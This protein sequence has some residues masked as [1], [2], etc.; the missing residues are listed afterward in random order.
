[1]TSW[2]KRRS[3]RPIFAVGAGTLAW[4]TI[5]A[6]TASGA[7]F[8]TPSSV[9]SF[10]LS[11]R[12]RALGALPTSGRAAFA[13]TGSQAQGGSRPH[14]MSEEVFKNIQVLKGIPVDEFM[15]TIDRK[16]TRLNSSHT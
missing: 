16:S 8:S 2:S 5:V 3:K 12:Q 14:R 11:N 9:A 15:G 4:L 10:D 6:L 13:Q 1:M 7:K